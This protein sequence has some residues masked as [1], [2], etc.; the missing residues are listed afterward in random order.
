[1]KIRKKSQNC[2]LSL[3]CLREG[4]NFPRFFIV[5]TRKKGKCSH[6]V[7]L[8]SKIYYYYEFSS[9]FLL[10]T[11]LIIYY[12]PMMVVVVF[13]TAFHILFIR[14]KQGLK[15]CCTFCILRSKILGAK[16]GKKKDSDKKR[17][18]WIFS[19]QWGTFSEFCWAAWNA[20]SYYFYLKL[21]C[22]TFWLKLFTEEN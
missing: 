8:S 3:L 15:I 16:F 1:M 9:V 2:A 14:S 13:V 10:Y 6:N 19:H 18:F 12:N 22:S 4:R 5:A 21:Y 11:L 7:S 20:K 17:K